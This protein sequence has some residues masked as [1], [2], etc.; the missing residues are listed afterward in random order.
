MNEVQICHKITSWALL[1]D[2]AET[3]CRR[4]PTNETVKTELI[5]LDPTDSFIDNK[6]IQSNPNIV[7][8]YFSHFPD[9]SVCLQG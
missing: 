1:N 2:V 9:D 5:G 4:I 3:S 6:I 8:Q 7:I